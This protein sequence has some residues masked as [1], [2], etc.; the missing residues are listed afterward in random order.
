MAVP[1]SRLEGSSALTQQDKRHSFEYHD[2]YLAHLERKHKIVADGIPKDFKGQFT[3]SP[4]FVE[5][6]K[7]CSTW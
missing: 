4:S 1:H 3:D 7:M 5:S 2:E 6:C